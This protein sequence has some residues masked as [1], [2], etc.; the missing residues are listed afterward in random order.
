MYTNIYNVAVVENGSLPSPQQQPR[1]QQWAEYETGSNAGHYRNW[2]FPIFNPIVHQQREQPT[3]NRGRQLKRTAEVPK[4][5][6]SEPRL[7]NTVYKVDSQRTLDLHGM[8]LREAM[9]AFLSF[10]QL[11]KSE[12]N[13][14]KDAATQFIS[15]ITGRGLHSKDGVPKIKPAVENYLRK[16]KYTYIWENPGKVVIDLASSGF[17]IDWD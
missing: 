17:P 6:K 8:F 12:F 2:E 11:C 10:L 5:S 16:H 3:E 1:F 4:R 15:I 14:K 7:A 9:R 13:A